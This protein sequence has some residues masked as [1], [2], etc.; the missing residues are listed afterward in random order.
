MDTRFVVGKIEVVG[1]VVVEKV[2]VVGM[3]VVEKVAVVGKVVGS[4]VGI[5]VG[6]IVRSGVFENVVVAVRCV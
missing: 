2:V 5:E 1:K 6:V 3:V 4:L